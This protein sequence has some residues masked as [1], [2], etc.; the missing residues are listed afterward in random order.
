[1]ANET[2]KK[3]IRRTT[4]PTVK[5]DATKLPVV[6]S[7]SKTIQN[8]MLFVLF[9]V[10]SGIV[11]VAIFQRPL[12]SKYLVSKSTSKPKITAA[13]TTSLLNTD[14][15]GAEDELNTFI[16]QD[17]PSKN[18][19]YP[20]G[21]NYYLVT[22]TFIFYPYAEKCRDRMKAQGYD[23]DIISTGENHKF[24]RVYI[25]SSTDGAAVRAKRDQLRSAGNTEVWVYVE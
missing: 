24:H 18:K 13:D 6:A 4:V 8:V 1:M 15:I 14:S 12:L 23:A 17:K 16:G 9:L 2:P 10:V 21:S 19:V 5:K 20:A 3:P 25:Q 11:Y 7:E 22:G